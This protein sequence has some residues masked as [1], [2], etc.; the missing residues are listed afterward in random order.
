MTTR[1]EA[2]FVTAFAELLK[3]KPE[4]FDSIPGPH[5]LRGMDFY[6]ARDLF[7]ALIEGGRF[8]YGVHNY[9]PS[10]ST[11]YS[12][13][14]KIFFR[15]YFG[16]VPVPSLGNKLYVHQHVNDT[17]GPGYVPSIVWHGNSL[18]SLNS[19]ELQKGQY[20]LKANHGS[21]MN[22]P[23]ASRESLFSDI[24]TYERL[25]QR[26]LSTNFGYSWGEWHYCCFKKEIFIE[27]FIDGSGGGVPIDYKFY[28]F[29]GQVRMIHVDVDRFTNHTRSFYTP[30]WQRV[31]ATLSYAPAPELPRPKQLERMIEIASQ[32]TAGVKFCRADLYLDASERIRVGELTLFPGNACERF[33]PIDFD[34]QLGQFI[35]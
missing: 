1:F 17:L 31:D 33:R 4:I 23:I 35:S 5:R 15:K 6:N 11:P 8:F 14:E 22:T 34:H 7:R 29:D 2:Y 32:L 10:L 19:N 3:E 18:Y 21:G 26:W 28:C 20:F 27:E 24:D 25:C 30:A 12:F 9:L 16:Y 13:S